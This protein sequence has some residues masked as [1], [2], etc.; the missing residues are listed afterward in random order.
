M[1]GLPAGLESRSPRPEAAGDQMSSRARWQRGGIA[2]AVYMPV[3]FFTWQAN[4]P[5]RVPPWSAFV[6]I[7]PVSPAP[8][9]EP[10]SSGHNKHLFYFI[11]TLRAAKVRCVAGRL[12]QAVRNTCAKLTE[13]IVFTTK[14]AL[15]GSCSYA[16]SPR[17]ARNK[18][19]TPTLAFIRLIQQISAL[20][21]CLHP[22]ETLAFCCT[23]TAS[24]I[25][26]SNLTRPSSASVLRRLW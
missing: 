9:Y 20:F 10:L 12:I 26:R 1:L 24:W 15:I 6:G 4:P 5:A 17:K 22:L 19:A 7:V 18:C 2:L 21:V 25:W 8:P 23:R 14:I 16:P 11:S 13:I 3:E